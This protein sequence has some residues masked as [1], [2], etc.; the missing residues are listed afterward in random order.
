M[1]NGRPINAKV[2]E[3]SLLDY[4]VQ[5]MQRIDAHK[6]TESEI[7]SHPATSVV[8]MRSS[9]SRSSSS[10][11]LRQCKGELCCAAQKSSSSSR[12]SSQAGFDE[13]LKHDESDGSD[14]ASEPLK[15]NRRLQPSWAVVGAALAAGVFVGSSAVLMWRQSKG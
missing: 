10:S 13:S 14:G 12:S 3:Y 1:R 11:L 15:S 8:A 2:P 9:S 7:S 6:R 4:S 5:E